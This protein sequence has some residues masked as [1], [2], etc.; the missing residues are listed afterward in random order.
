MKIYSDNTNAARVVHPGYAVADE[1]EALGIGNQQASQAFGITPKELQKLY[2]GEYDITQIIANALEQ[3]GSAEASFWLALQHNYDM[4]PKRGGYRQGSG[5]KKK[6]FI[7]KQVRISAPAEEMSKIQA[8]LEA[9]PN[10]SRALA[11]LILG[12]P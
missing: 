2:L 1:L 4:H 10:T 5:R 7:S 8:W 11:D 6:D 9:Q 3:L 12:A